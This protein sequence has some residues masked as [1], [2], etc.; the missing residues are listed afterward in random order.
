M[1]DITATTALQN[2]NW[3]FVRG[4]TMQVPFTL[5][6]GT[7]P[8]KLSDCSSIIFSLKAKVSDTIY[9]LQKTYEAN[10]GIEA[11]DDTNG[12][13]QVVIAPGD[14]PALVKDVTYFYDLQVT[15][16][17]SIIDRVTTVMR[18]TFT[19]TDDVTK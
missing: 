16:S 15:E 1:A 5:K 2:T 12:I 17:Q 14:S 13:G 11:I 4:D 3:A 10:G 6:I 9:I 18:G 19:M 8:L 7:T